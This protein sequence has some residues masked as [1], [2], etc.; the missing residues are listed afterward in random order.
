MSVDGL[1]AAVAE[2]GVVFAGVVVVALASYL[3]GRA[4]WSCSDSLFGSQHPET[5]IEEKNVETESFL[6]FDFPAG[7]GW[8][9]LDD[10]LP[11]G[12]VLP[13]DVEEAEYSGLQDGLPEQEGMDW[14]SDQE[15]PKV[16]DQ[17]S[18]MRRGAYDQDR[19]P[20][21]RES[22]P[23]LSCSLASP[24]EPQWVWMVMGVAVAVVAVAAV[25]L[26]VVVVVAAVMVIEQVVKNPTREAPKWRKLA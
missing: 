17:N 5:W 1:A 9:P 6:S 13:K 11:T 15:K 26:V 12:W 3:F 4:E 10:W 19:C 25:V 2:S 18:R 23:S 14:E 20:G 21:R 16:V 8:L 22:S 7:V 24:K